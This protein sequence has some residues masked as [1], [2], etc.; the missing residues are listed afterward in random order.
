M[1]DVFMVPGSPS[2]GLSEKD[3][4][5]G[6]RGGGLSAQKGGYIYQTSWS[7][8]VKY[9]PGGHISGFCLCLWVE[10]KDGEIYNNRGEDGRGRVI[11][12]KD[13]LK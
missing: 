3:E 13:G 8:G 12:P 11:D 2:G 9:P 5:F 1:K 4:G 6:G 7:R 10:G